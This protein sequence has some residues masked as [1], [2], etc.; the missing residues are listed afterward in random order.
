MGYEKTKK[1]DDFWGAVRPKNHQTAEVLWI[2][3][4]SRLNQPQLFL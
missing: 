4:A 2:Y 1:F 3:S